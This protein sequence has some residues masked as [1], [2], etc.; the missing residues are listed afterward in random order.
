MADCEK[1]LLADTEAICLEESERRVRGMA[2]LSIVRE[3]CLSEALRM[4]KLVHED[5]VYDRFA[6]TSTSTRRASLDFPH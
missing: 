1:V 4:M 5:D 6:F 3:E 2:I